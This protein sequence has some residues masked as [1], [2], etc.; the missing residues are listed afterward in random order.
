MHSMNTMWREFKSRVKW[1]SWN[2]HGKEIRYAAFWHIVKD[3]K[4]Y[5][6]LENHICWK[7]P[8]EA[9]ILPPIHTLQQS[10]RNAHIRYTSLNTNTSSTKSMSFE[11][12][13]SW[14]LHLNRRSM[15]LPLA[16][17][18]TRAACGASCTPKARILDHHVSKYQACW[19]GEYLWLSLNLIN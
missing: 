15:A 14:V 2:I 5:S 19:K 4:T 12:T 17:T 7:E 13:L 16:R 11:W 18:F 10:W 6:A 9:S 3:P 8:N 1:G